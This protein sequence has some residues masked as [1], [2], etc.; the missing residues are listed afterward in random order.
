MLLMGRVVLL[1]LAAIAAS[2]GLPDEAPDKILLPVEVAG[3][4]GTVAKGMAS[5]LTSFCLLHS[6]GWLVPVRP[7][8]T[9]QSASIALGSTQ[10]P[11]PTRPAMQLSFVCPVPRFANAEPWD[12]T[13]R[14][15]FQ[16]TYARALSL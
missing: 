9:L 11:S 6:A 7:R 16:W 2:I 1:F 13:F 14:D 10:L 15:P 4:D 5:F 8:A 12:R 3:A